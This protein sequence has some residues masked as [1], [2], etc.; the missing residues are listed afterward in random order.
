[1]STQQTVDDYIAILSQ[2]YHTTRGTDAVDRL[3][4]S[5]DKRAIEPLLGLLQA[6]DESL[7]KAAEEALGKLGASKEQV[8]RAHIAVLVVRVRTLGKAIEV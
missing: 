3:G 7:R 1:M 8:A 4:D 5:G 2:E 6:E